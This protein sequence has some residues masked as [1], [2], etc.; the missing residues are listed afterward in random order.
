MQRE[1]WGREKRE[2][3]G[4]IVRLRL[5]SVIFQYAAYALNHYIYQFTDAQKW[6]KYFHMALTS[7]TE[8]AR[9][10]ELAEMNNYAWMFSDIL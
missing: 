9:G 5:D 6:S 2:R 4:L 8:P 1:R 7:T 10:P 3:E